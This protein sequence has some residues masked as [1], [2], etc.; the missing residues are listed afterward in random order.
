MS[1][2]VGYYPSRDTDKDRVGRGVCVN[3]AFSNLNRDWL[4]R[5]IKVK[6]AKL[7]SPVQ[8]FKNHLP[9]CNICVI[10]E[11]MHFSVHH[12]QIVSFIQ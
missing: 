10:S 11:E 2:A 7:S 12:K 3:E 4:C 5:S 9:K 8:R 1:S 6:Y